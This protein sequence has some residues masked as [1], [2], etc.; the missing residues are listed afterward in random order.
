MISGNPVNIYIYYLYTNC[1]HCN[2]LTSAAELEIELDR[3]QKI[4]LRSVE[5]TKAFEKPKATE[6]QLRHIEKGI[7]VCNT[8]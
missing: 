2:I 3:R 4:E 1:S 8:V 5:L 7:S 6:Y